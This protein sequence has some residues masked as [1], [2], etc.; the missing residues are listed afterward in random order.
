MGVDAGKEDQE[1]NYDDMYTSSDPP[2]E[3]AEN[4]MTAGKLYISAQY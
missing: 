2:V 3:G 4:N 1:E